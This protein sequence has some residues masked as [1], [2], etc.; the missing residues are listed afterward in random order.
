MA[1]EALFTVTCLEKK[2]RNFVKRMYILA[3]RRL[4]QHRF[5]YICIYKGKGKLDLMNAYDNY[6]VFSMFDDRFSF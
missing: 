1:K 6:F 2:S 3:V 5:Y 4:H